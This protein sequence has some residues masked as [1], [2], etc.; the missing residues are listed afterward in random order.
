MKWIIILKKKK[1]IVTCENAQVEK[2]ARKTSHPVHC[3]YLLEA[4]AHARSHPYCT[5]HFTFSFCYPFRC[6]PPNLPPAPSPPVSRSLTLSSPFRVSLSVS[7]G[8]VPLLV[9]FPWVIPIFLRRCPFSPT[10][11]LREYN[12][13]EERKWNCPANSVVRRPMA[14]EHAAAG[15]G[16]WFCEI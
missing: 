6:L 4:T 9:L 3:R 12:I 11:V 8:A 2:R 13:Q 14:E 1:E 5:N 10:A 15:G 16:G 7:R